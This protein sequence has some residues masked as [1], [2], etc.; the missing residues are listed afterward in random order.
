MV[1]DHKPARLSDTELRLLRVFQ[2]VVRNHGFASAE[3]ELGISPATI[4]NHI[5]QL[6]QRLGIRL[7]RR[8]RAGF[9]L[10][11]E[12]A[13]I[14]EASLN[15]FRSVENFSSIVASVRGELTGAVHFGTVDAVYSNTILGLQ[16]AIA[17]FVLQAPR[18]TLHI[19]IASPQDLRQRLL[20]GRYQLILTP[21]EDEHPSIKATRLFDETQVLLCGRKHPLFRVSRRSLSAEAILACPYAERSYAKVPPELGLGQTQTAAL[22]SHMETLALLILSGAFVGHLPEHYAKGWLQ[23]REMRRIGAEG[24]SYS[25]TFRLASLVSEQN[26]AAA[27]LQDCVIAN[28]DAT[29]HSDPAL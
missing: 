6:E 29:N 23:S 28:C 2:A 7:C 25:S 26:R 11:D 9:S 10:T 18:V 14:H 19:D 17:A 1:R 24:M 15:L 3:T 20:D 16:R 22:T 4:S 21:I 27:L 12:G 5:A 8:G 13:R